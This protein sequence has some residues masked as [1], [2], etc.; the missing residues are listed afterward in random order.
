MLGLVFTSPVELAVW[1]ISRDVPVPIQFR[2]GLMHNVISVERQW[3][4]RMT[5]TF[6]NGS[7]AFDVDP[8]CF[9]TRVMK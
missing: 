4:L 7:I 2:T 6:D 3:D 5:L 1:E 9:V 8:D